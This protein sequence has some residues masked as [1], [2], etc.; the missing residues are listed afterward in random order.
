MKIF[1]LEDMIGGWF[2]G[3]FSPTAFKTHN[4]EVSYK[5][6]PKG[7]V[8]DKHYHEHL[9]EINLLIEGEMIIKNTKV[10]QGEIFILEPKEIAD[11]VFLEECKII[12]VKIPNITGDKIILD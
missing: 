8:W 1:K 2:V 4:A 11:P 5:I 6:H 10:R 7:E 12:C 9:T 3:N